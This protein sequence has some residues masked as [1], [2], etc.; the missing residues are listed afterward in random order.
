[1]WK[2][3]SGTP[4]EPCSECTLTFIGQN[5][6]ILLGGIGKDGKIGKGFITAVKLLDFSNWVSWEEIMFCQ[7]LCHTVF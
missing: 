1:M 3:I 7:T 2:K 5:Q 6:A 4:P